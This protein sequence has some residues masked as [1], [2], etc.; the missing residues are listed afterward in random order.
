M[1]LQS[2]AALRAQF[3]RSTPEKPGKKEIASKQQHLRCHALL[4]LFKA[5]GP[6]TEAIIV[7]LPTR[8]MNERYH[9][10]VRRDL[11]NQYESHLDLLRLGGFIPE[12]PGKSPDVWR[13]SVAMYCAADTDRD[14][15]TGLLKWPLDWLVKHKYCVDDNDRHLEIVE[16]THAIDRKVPRIEFRTIA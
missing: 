7:P 3:N 16:F 8:I 1:K 4:E 2:T 9:W 5:T 12:P 10:A 13:V 14:N 11:Q 6:E 15:A